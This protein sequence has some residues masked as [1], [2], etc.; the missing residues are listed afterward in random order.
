MA[1][2]R[3]GEVAVGL[4]ALPGAALRLTHAAGATVNTALLSPLGQM[5]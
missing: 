3:M 2:D 1:T 4:P 5:T